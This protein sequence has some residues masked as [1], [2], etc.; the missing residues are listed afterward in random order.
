MIRFLLSSLGFIICLSCCAGNNKKLPINSVSVEQQSSME[1]TPEELG[2][3]PNTRYLVSDIVD[4]QGKKIKMPKSVT[5]VFKGGSI[6]NGCII[7]NDS[8]IECSNY[9]VFNNVRIAG[10]WLVPK[11]STSMFADLDYVNSLRDVFALSN[12][13][14]NNTIRINKG[15]YKVCV[16]KNKEV[17]LPVYS[18]TTIIIDGTIMLQPNAFPRYDIMCVN[19]ENITISGSG[20]IVGDKHTHKGKDGQWG[21]GIRFHGAK[22]TTVMG[23]SIRE[24]WGDCIYVGGNSKNVKILQ[25][26]L[27]HGRRQGISVTKADNVLI[28]ECKISNVGGQKPEYAIDLEPNQGDTVDNVMIEN[29][30]IVDCKGGILST[31]GN[32]DGRGKGSYIGSIFVKKCKISIVDKYP[33]RLRRCEKADVEG[34]VTY[35]TNENP[36]IFMSEINEVVVFDNEINVD[37]RIMASIKNITKDVVGKS[38]YKPISVSRCKKKMIDNNIIT[39][40]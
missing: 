20:T 23:L 33:I 25:C 14:V 6:R 16:K 21:M 15:E 27:D 19:G 11:I 4:L 30:E 35:S 2:I 22:N 26:N 34:C 13:L 38:K 5:L 40:K 8:K 12:P 36:S 3:Y 1:I 37:K 28:R 39:E 32:K 7:G 29:V 17:C 18:N 31:K 10:I 24:C 9:P